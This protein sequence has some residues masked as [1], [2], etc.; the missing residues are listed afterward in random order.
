MVVGSLPVCEH[1]CGSR[2]VEMMPKVGRAGVVL[3]RSLRYFEGQGPW[4]LQTGLNYDRTGR[5]ATIVVTGP[6]F[7]GRAGEHGPYPRS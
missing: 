3:K 4:P 5:K 7:S 1:T 2:A 6:L